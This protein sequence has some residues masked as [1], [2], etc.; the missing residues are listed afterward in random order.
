MAERGPA[1]RSPDA[2]TGNTRPPP[3]GLL[4][5][6]DV[7]F[8]VGLIL[9]SPFLLL[10]MAT[11]ERYRKGMLERLALRLPAVQSGPRPIWIHAASAGEMVAAAALAQKLR[12]R[13]PDQPL[14][15]SSVTTSG[16]AVARRLLPELPAFVLPLDFGPCVRRVLGR[17]RPRLLVLVE[18]ELWPNLVSA[19]FRDGVGLVVANGRIGARSARSYARWPVRRLVG[20]DRVDLFCVQSEEHRQRLESLRVD[21]ARIEV[22]G[23]M[24]IDVPPGS[25]NRQAVRDRLGFGE[26]DL[27]VVA[28][29]TH[30]GE[31]ALVGAAVRDLR[32]RFDRPLRLLIAPRHR[33]RLAEAERDLQN[34]GLDPVRLTRVD[35]TGGGSDVVVIDTMGELAELYRC[36]DVALV[37]GSLVTGIG[38]HNVFE[39]VLAG[40]RTLVG[41]HHR[42]VRS[43]VLFLAGIG[44]VEVVTDAA[45]LSEMLGR[46]LGSDGGL[47]ETVLRELELARGAAQRTCEWIEEH[48]L[49]ESA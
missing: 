36:A 46:V 25:G 7:L 45:D 18:L 15:L 6:Y 34:A 47:D 43:D 41:A 29:S 10:R 12:E 39:P 30:P 1:S 14:L 3:R 42:N 17:L 44:A 19:A 5:L 8:L 22:S 40:A 9:A 28:G 31:E 16:V 2:R 11:R 24:K 27:V 20:L 13:Q 32:V 48:C 49:S 33:E 35:A 37:G 38:G 4:L 26:H 21:P 23:N